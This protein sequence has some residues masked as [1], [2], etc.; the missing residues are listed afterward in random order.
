M[1]AGSGEVSTTRFWGILSN[2]CLISFFDPS[3][4]SMRKGRNRGEKNGGEKNTSLA[5][6]GALAHRL[7]RRT[8]YKIQKGRQGL[9]STSRFLGLLSN[10]R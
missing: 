9:M 7:Q 5:A 6:K 3:T 1:A 4:P 8:A 10:F 2:F